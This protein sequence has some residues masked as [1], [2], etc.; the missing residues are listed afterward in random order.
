MR[1]GAHGNF[2]FHFVLNLSTAIPNQD[3]RDSNTLKKCCVYW[4][5]YLTLWSLAGVFC[6]VIDCDKYYLLKLE[7]YNYWGLRRYR[8]DKKQGCYLRRKTTYLHER[9]S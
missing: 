4:I 3:Y 6:L 1:S 2:L 9:T 7:A 5:I 8:E